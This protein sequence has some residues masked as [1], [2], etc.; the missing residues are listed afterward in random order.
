MPRHRTNNS[1]LLMK[2]I[3]IGS[4]LIL[5]GVCQLPA[6]TF[7]ASV[8]KTEVGQNEVF[9]VYFKLENA[10]TRDITYPSFDNFRVRGGLNTSTS[11]QI[12]NGQVTQSTT[13][14]FYLQAPNQGTFTIGAASADVNGKTL[15]TEPLTIKVVKASASKSSGGKASQGGGDA[16]VSGDVMEQIRNNVFVRAL[17]S[18]ST[19]YRG[20]PLTLTYKLYTR[21][22]MSNPYL[23]EAPTYKGFW[24]EELDVK[25]PPRSE[26][27]KG[28]EYRTNVIKQ[29][30]LFP[31][32]TGEL[33]INPIELETNVRVMV[34]NQSR[35]RRSIF[36]DFF[37]QY[38]DVP[39]TFSSNAVRIESRP[40][41]AGKPA[42]F[43][44]A[45]GSF[46]LQLSLDKD[47]TETG[48]PVTLKA[49]IT[50]KGNINMISLGELDFP[51]DFDVYDPTVSDNVRK[52]AGGLSGAKSFD[53]LIIPRNPGEYKLPVVS[54][55]YF[56]P[57]QGRYITRTSEEFVLTVTG[58]PQQSS[59]TYGNISKE[60]VELIGEDIRYI[61]PASDAF[62][63]IGYS[64]V[65]TPLFWGLFLLPFALFGGMLFWKKRQ[66][67]LLGDQA[68]LRSRKAQ[69]KARQQLAVAKTYMEQQREKDFY[70]EIV[71]A[72]WG[73]VGD[74]LNIGQ[75]ELT[76]E[77]VREQLLARGVAEDLIARFT[78]LLDTCEMALF[79]PTAVEGGMDSVYEEA[80]QLIVDIENPLKETSPVA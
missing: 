57:D 20:E 18:K 51:P 78:Q 43:S 72:L 21:A 28:V 4:V 65:Q 50:G 46:N 64:F 48:E 59:V 3:F 23:T 25:D 15:S 44:G 11:M 74:K 47:S 40:L 53:Y 80:T 58:E 19:V 52:S 71:R 13:Y 31:Q 38:Q 5:L 77:N 17:V 62:R 63:N 45:V 16:Q 33:T 9:E 39:Y 61:K 37:G 6:Q 42:D 8:N 79:A 73:Y 66:D 7:T 55:S 36:D 26:V 27:Y 32:Q 41:P 76:R 60:D 29:V 69:K 67:K 22:Q 49:R 54:F 2:S 30:L 14:S 24:V 56:D 1:K 70:D 10:Q 75:S 12:V 34:Q 35:R 68:G